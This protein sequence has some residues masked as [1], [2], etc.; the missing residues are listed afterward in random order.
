MQFTAETGDQSRNNHA[1]LH[2]GYS[3][4]FISSMALHSGHLET[5]NDA[6]SRLQLWRQFYLGNLID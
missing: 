6:R 5:E 1:A 4:N 3:H 2:G